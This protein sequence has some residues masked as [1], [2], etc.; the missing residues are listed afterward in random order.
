VKSFDFHDLF[1]FDLANNH[2]G[3]VELGTMIIDRCADVVSHHGVR[4][5]L[6]FQFRDLDTFVH[7]DHVDRST[8]NNV[9]RFLSTRL[10]WDDYYRLLTIVK[11][12]GLIAM[13][14][15][16]DEPSVDKIVEMKFEAIKIASCSA[17]DWPLLERAVAVGLPMII[18]TGGLT[19]DQVD[20]VVSFLEHRGS[21]FALM[22]CVSI[23]PTLDVACNLGN[24]ARL[25]ARYPGRIIGWSTHEKPAD[26]VPIGIAAALGA[27]LFE[28]HVGVA[29]NAVKLN[30]YSATPE[31]IDHWIEAWKKVKTLIG[32]NSCA[33]R[34]PEERQTIDG[35]RRGVF[36]LRPIEAGVVLTREDVYFAFPC[37]AGG[38]SSG[39]WREG[40]M[41]RGEI[42]ADAPVRHAA[43]EI[44]VDPDEII[45]KDAVHEAKGLLNL[46]HVRLTTDFTVEYSHHYG[47]RN[48]R[49]FGAILI[50]V[51]NREYCKKVLVQLPGQIHPW[52][53][54]KRKEETFLLLYGT[55]HV[56]VED[57]LKLLRPGDTLLILPGVWHRFWSEH[58][59]VF[60]ELSTTHFA[61]DSVYRDDAINK[62]TKE[63]RKT[64]VDHWGRFQI[65]DQIREAQLPA[66]SSFDSQMEYVTSDKAS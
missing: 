21:S 49:K 55:L 40:I 65:S 26:M 12:R 63:Q 10:T 9:R 64:V 60:E 11:K 23:Y 37:A 6:K 53:F 54:H 42:A 31:Q 48:F 17:N 39:E 30:A 25:R 58:G 3:S 57:R 27:E 18:S 22:H 43:V 62:L 8:N 13:C 14:T 46:A 59:C 50:N 28:R 51:I 56:Q 33:A 66:Q 20:D 7:S 2:Q 19:V 5:A 36:A 1:I 32:P 15:P 34:L 44:P 61:N 52:H 35:L 29:T 24:I 41:T 4:A 45:L 16:F 38:L 47:V